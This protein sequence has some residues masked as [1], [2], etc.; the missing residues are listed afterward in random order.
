MILTIVGLS[1]WTYHLRKENQL[2]S[3]EYQDS[4]YHYKNKLDQTYLAQDLIQIDLDS[5]RR[6]NNELGE[7]IRNLKEN[8]FIITKVETIFQDADIEAITD[9]IR[10]DLEK[11]TV[12]Y[13]WHVEKSPWYLLEGTSSFCFANNS[14]ST[15]IKQVKMNS[16]I[17]LDVIEN[18]P[19]FTI[20][21]RTENPY[22][23]VTSVQSAMIDVNQSS[24]IKKATKKKWS[25]GP[26]VG[27]GLGT[28]FDNMKFGFQVGIGIQY[29]IWSW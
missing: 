18:G 24:V 10:K 3:I 8:P 23:D 13:D 2:L 17:W 5:L 9:S 29:S 27:V 6:M 14:T 19:K 12:A 28:S 15:F 26:Y 11:S 1:I 7:E 25:V 20:I 22:L 4:L 21:A 16:G